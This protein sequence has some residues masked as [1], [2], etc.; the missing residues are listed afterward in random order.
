MSQ[1]YIA[2]TLTLLYIYIK[3]RWAIQRNQD[4]SPR[5]GGFSFSSLFIVYLFIRILL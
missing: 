5:R 1:R 3:A 4:T 2:Y